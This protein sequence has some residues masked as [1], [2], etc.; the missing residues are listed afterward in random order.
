ME[1]QRLLPLT[2]R[3]KGASVSLVGPIGITLRDKCSPILMARPCLM[4]TPRPNR[5]LAVSYGRAKLV[6]E[7]ITGV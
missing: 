2:R 1:V 4:Q 5:H 6:S 7:R 3:V